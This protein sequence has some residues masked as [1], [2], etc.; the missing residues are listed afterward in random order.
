MSWKM[1][2]LA[3]LRVVIESMENVQEKK[4][5]GLYNKKRMVTLMSMAGSWRTLQITKHETQKQAN[6]H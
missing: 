1:C 3:R 5:R 6:M 4:T 2:A